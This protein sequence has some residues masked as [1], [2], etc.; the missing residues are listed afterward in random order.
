MLRESGRSHKIN[1]PLESVTN[2]IFL[3][4]ESQDLTEV[5]EYLATADTELSRAFSM[6]IGGELLVRSREGQDWQS[7]RSGMV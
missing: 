6:A 2:L 3:A 7:G 4:R 1:N 5:G